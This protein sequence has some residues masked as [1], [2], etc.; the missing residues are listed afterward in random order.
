VL[1]YW[2]STALAD[3]ALASVVISGVVTT[4]LVGGVYWIDRRHEGDE[5]RATVAEPGLRDR[6]NARVFPCGIVAGSSLVLGR[7]LALHFPIGPG[8][9]SPDRGLAQS[10]LRKEGGRLVPC[11]AI[12]VAAPLPSRFSDAGG[13]V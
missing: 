7:L 10:P 13:P 12:S 11:R 5:T 6:A 3:F 4:I 2:I 1:A 8:A 9:P